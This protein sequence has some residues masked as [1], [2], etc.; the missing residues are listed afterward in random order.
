MLSARKPAE[1]DG[2]CC[3]WTLLFSVLTQ[4]AFTNQSTAARISLVDTNSQ[5]KEKDQKSDLHLFHASPLLFNTLP[6]R[7]NHIPPI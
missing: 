5:R 1:K 2:I 7:N 6:I 4:F 3:Y